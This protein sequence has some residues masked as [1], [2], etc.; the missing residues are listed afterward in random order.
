MKQ[1]KQTDFEEIVAEMGGL[2]D[3]DLLGLAAKHPERYHQAVVQHFRDRRYKLDQPLLLT[4]GY[5]RVKYKP[6]HTFRRMTVAE[7]KQLKSGH[8]ATVMDFHGEARNVKVNGRPRTWKRKFP[9]VVVPLK[10]GLYEYFDD[11]RQTFT[12]DQHM[13]YL[14]VEV[15]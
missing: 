13:R 6:I 11:D 1:I 15:P 8:V 4:W 12:D 5:D 7:A 2:T 10:Y 3:E 14:I 9:G